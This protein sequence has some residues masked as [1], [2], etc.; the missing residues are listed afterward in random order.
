MKDNAKC[1]KPSDFLVVRGAH[2]V[3]TNVTIR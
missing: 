1:I 2:K 3:I